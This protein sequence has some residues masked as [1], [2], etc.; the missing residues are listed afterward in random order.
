MS[1][2]TKYQIGIIILPGQGTKEIILFGKKFKVYLPCQL[3]YWAKP[4]TNGDGDVL[5]MIV[6]ITAFDFNM[7]GGPKEIFFPK[8]QIQVKI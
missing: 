4:I 5:A 3:E 8:F 7:E 6:E 1:E 2:S